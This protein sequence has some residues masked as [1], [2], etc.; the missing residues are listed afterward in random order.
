MSTQCRHMST[1]ARTRTEGKIRSNPRPPA[2]DLTPLA[3]RARS[4]IQNPRAPTCAHARNAFDHITLEFPRTRLHM[5]EGVNESVSLNPCA[6]AWART[7]RGDSTPRVLLVRLWSLPSLS[8]G[9]FRLMRACWDSRYFGGSVKFLVR[10]RAPRA[11]WGALAGGSEWV[12]L[13]SPP[14]PPLLFTS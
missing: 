2:Y 8:A 5:R 13:Y 4:T 14:A 11:K 1:L 7:R 12:V 6:Y 10:V 3:R 9:V